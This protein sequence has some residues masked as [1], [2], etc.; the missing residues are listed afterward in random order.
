MREALDEAFGCRRFRLVELAPEEF[1][2]LDVG[3][4]V[5]APLEGP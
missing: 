1:E 5:E 2:D 4:V 3:P